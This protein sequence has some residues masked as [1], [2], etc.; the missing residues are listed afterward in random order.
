MRIN[1]IRRQTVAW[2]IRILI[3]VCLSSTA[4]FAADEAPGEDVVRVGY[5]SFDGYHNLDENGVRS[6][7]GYE[8]LQKAAQYVAFQYRYIGYD[9]SWAQ[10]QQM[11]IDGEID[12]VTSAQ[13]TPERMALFDFS[14]QPIGNSATI[15]TVKSGNSKITAGDYASYN[16]MR[17]GMLEDSTRNDSFAKFADENGFS[18]ETVFY[19]SVALLEEALQQGDAVDAIVTSNL[20]AICN[21]WVLEKFDPSDFYVMVRK[22]DLALL[23]KVNSAIAQM[24]NNDAG[25]RTQLFQK[26]Y[27]PDSGE[28]IAFTPQERSYLDQLKRED[29]VFTAIVNPDR[30]PYSYFENG[31]A[32]G[33]MVEIFQKAAERA[34]LQYT[35]V[36]TADRQQYADLAKTAQIDIRIDTAF[37][38]FYAEEDGYN[39]TDP[40]LTTTVSMLTKKG[41]TG[42]IASVAVLADSDNRRLFG[43]S[44]YQAEQL[45]ECSSVA[46]CVDAVKNGVA[47]GTYL[48]TYAAQQYMQN[49]ITNALSIKLVPNCTMRF[50]VAASNE[51]N[52]L[53][54]AVLNKAVKSISEDEIQ[55]I[56]WQQTEYIRS[57]ASFTAFVY[58]NPFTAVAM[59]LIVISC[60]TAFLLVL[61]QNKAAKKMQIQANERAQALAEAEKANQAKYDFLSNMSHDMRT[62][63]NGMIGLLELTLDT[64]DLPQTV[65]ENLQSMNKSS[66]YLLSLI[67]DT[68]DMSKIESNMLSLHYETVDTAEMVKSVAGYVTST[69]KAKG[70]A[71]TITN[72]DAELGYIK[73][74]PLRLQQI[75]VNI[76][77]NAI[78]F[79]PAGGRVDVTIACYKREDGVAHDRISVK[80]SGIGMSK[81]FLSKIFEPF[82]RE[83]AMSG[84]MAAGTG[85]GMSIVKNLVELM[86]GKVE[87][88]SEKGVGTE[89]VVWL[90]FERV[91]RNAAD[92]DLSCQAS[93]SYRE[94]LT[95]KRVLLVEDHPLNTKVATKLLEKVGLAVEHAENGEVAVE[96]FGQSAPFYYSAV[97]MDI[98]MPV[99]DGLAATEK[100]RALER[101]DAAAVPIIA[102]TANAFADDVQKTKAA[103]MNA[104]LAKPIEPQRMY[105]TLCALIDKKTD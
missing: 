100:I 26:Y 57:R 38:Y 87:V 81:E 5:F 80:D 17:V 60:F 35:I 31:Q 24:D 102:M 25:W 94:I 40:Y 32:K 6:G 12:L 11:L 79:T 50:S 42:D 73:T 39:L 96:K 90:A 61:L 89:V 68:L 66:Q 41:H 16:G 4:A 86:G 21:E 97:L 64:P 15:L 77:S 45:V 69:A 62:P 70:I 105:E 14:D 63:M 59:M 3:A 29:K 47:D 44:L 103:G 43:D 28:Q 48:Y 13:K 72:K 18:Y 20:R 82:E 51:K 99:M 67:N 85:L 74:D 101:I 76:V 58:D 88:F 10:M 37:D 92:V 98:R 84:D 53:L 33:I 8:F 95:G 7:Y 9:Q 56:V 49:D 91:H 93:V 2:T 34:G 78:K 65:V 83:N 36:E 27:T 54:L 1:R 22:G 52:R 75:F 71:L 55:N 46:D 30:A 19:D 104:H 23:D